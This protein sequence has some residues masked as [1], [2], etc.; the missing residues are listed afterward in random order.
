MAR[1]G[2]GMR[3][4]AVGRRSLDDLER[5]EGRNIDAIQR[6]FGVNEYTSDVAAMLSQADVSVAANRR[7]AS[8]RSIAIRDQRIKALR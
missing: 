6:K 7:M 4:I 3:V 1:F 2:F 5:D 8:G